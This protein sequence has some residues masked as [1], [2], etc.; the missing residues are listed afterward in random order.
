[1]RSNVADLSKRAPDRVGPARGLE[2]GHGLLARRELGAVPDRPIEPA[3]QQSAAHRRRAA[4][5][6]ARECVLGP[7]AEARLDFEVP[8][9][10]R[11]HDQR[12]VAP[13]AL[14]GAQVRDLPSL[15]VFDVLQQAAGGADG[16]RDI[17]GVEA[18]EVAHAELLREQPA[19]GLG[20]EM[21]GGAAAQARGREK[22]G[23][24]LEGLGDEQLRRPET[25]ELGRERLEVLELV[26]REMPAREVEP[27]ESDLPAARVDAARIDGASV[28]SEGGE[29]ARFPVAEQ[30]RVR[31]RAWRHD[32]H[33]LAR[34]GALARGRV[35]GLLADRDGFTEFD[36]AREVGLDRVH[37]HPGHRDRRARGLAALRQRDVDE[38]RGA[39]RIVV[40]ELVEVAH[41]VEQ[42]DVRVLGLDGQVLLHDG[43]MGGGQGR[44]RRAWWSFGARSPVTGH[45]LPIAGCRSS[46]VGRQLPVVGCQEAIGVAV[47]RSD[48][49]EP[50]QDTRSRAS[51]RQAR[52]RTIIER[53][54]LRRPRADRG[55][56]FR[57][58]PTAL[59][60]PQSGRRRE[61]AQL[62]R[63]QYPWQTAGYLDSI[64]PRGGARFRHDHRRFVA[65]TG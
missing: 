64:V 58:R 52:T 41:T 40:E 13:L 27:R 34:D 45:R 56:R 30:R 55:R 43:G 54:V 5:H 47:G 31:Q 7:V 19:A 35:A 29:V 21:P 26:E 46:V 39:A 63:L 15:R 24:L 33:D 65:L 8:A 17:L 38:L 22:P 16:E 42:Q 1:M 62:E 51:F 37:G 2:L 59:A 49:S 6:E 20:L 18:R 44:G 23:G 50:G 61:A 28:D 12:L 57:D 9:S 32:A 14:D 60:E 53:R 3:P 25:L 48:C 11:V 36:E 4:V 10:R